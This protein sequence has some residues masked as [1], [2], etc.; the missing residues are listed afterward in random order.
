MKPSERQKICSHCDGRIPIDAMQCLYCGADASKIA[1]PSSFSKHQALED[2]LTSLYKP[3]YSKPNTTPSYSPPLASEMK[4]VEESR[5]FRE[6]PPMAASIL[7][8]TACRISRKD[9]RS[10][11]C[12]SPK[13]G[14]RIYQC[15]GVGV[16]Q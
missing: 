7:P 12:G 8:E 6:A 2:S 4:P 14:E 11:T 10:Q 13:S 9:R 15:F 1:E 5:R 16:N 3:Q